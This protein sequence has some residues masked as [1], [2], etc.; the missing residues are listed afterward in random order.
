MFNVG[1]A[2]SKTVTIIM[3]D[4]EGH[5]DPVAVTVHVSV[6]DV[7]ISPAAGVYIDVGEVLS[8]NMPAPPLHIPVSPDCR[9]ADKAAIEL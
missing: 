8:E 6:T 3:S 7:P 5:T 9:V 4:S 2:S 1:T